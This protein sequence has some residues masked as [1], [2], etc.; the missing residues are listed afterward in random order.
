MSE[1]ICFHCKYFYFSY[2]EPGYSEYTPG[3]DPVIECDKNH[4]DS[5]DALYAYNGL[6]NCMHK[7]ETCKDYELSDLAK[8]HGVTD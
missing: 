1:R 5:D 2:G 8:E 7:A 4:W 6:F 3:S